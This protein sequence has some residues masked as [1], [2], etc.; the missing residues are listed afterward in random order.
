MSKSIIFLVNDFW[1]TFI[2]IW[3]FFLVT[4]E[5]SKG[6]NFEFDGG[7]GGLGRGGV[8]EVVN[9]LLRVLNVA[10]SWVRI[11]SAKD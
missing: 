6:T 7:G 10:Q 1:A 5:P 9:H 11:T 3:Q 4:L 8:G 2:D